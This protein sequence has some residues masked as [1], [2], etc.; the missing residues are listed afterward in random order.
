M[1]KK[2]APKGI[3]LAE[4]EPEEKRPTE[5]LDLGTDLLQRM[6]RLLPLRSLI[7]LK[8]TCI[9][10]NNIVGNRP[11]TMSFSAFARSLKSIPAAG[12]HR[13]NLFIRVAPANLTP[14]QFVYLAQI[15]HL[16]FIEFL[17]MALSRFPRYVFQQC[18]R[19][20]IQQRIGAQPRIVHKLVTGNY[21]ANITI[22][23]HSV[24]EHA[25]TVG[26]P[27]LVEYLCQIDKFDPGLNN[28][29][30]LRLAAKNG[31]ASCLKA[32]LKHPKSD[33]TSEDN[34]AIRLASANGHVKCVKLLLLSGKVDCQARDN[35]ALIRAS[36]AGHLLIVI[37]LLR[38]GAKPKARN[39]QSIYLAHAN[40]HI[41]LRDHLFHMC[42][43]EASIDAAFCIPFCCK[44]GDFEI[45]KELIDV[46]MMNPAVRDNQAL[47]NAVDSDRADIVKY[48]LKDSR[49]DPSSRSNYA[50][51]KN[52][53][54]RRLLEGDQRVQIEVERQRLLEPKHF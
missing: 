25:A 4:L 33:P 20:A 5:L 16:D 38:N 19:R 28:H 30:S 48:L 15:G 43:T 11:F 36:G 34:E 44:I 23:N 52:S 6:S 9:R 35:E 40:K 49:V 14:T 24:L 3:K 18:F 1:K 2:K 10:L 50:F 26:N 32:L 53:D 21:L 7:R 47:K 8:Q 37:N 51:K 22:D 54:W 41:E 13:L 17:P 12:Y 27:D 31:R 42:L 46:K 39:Y 45:L 29:S